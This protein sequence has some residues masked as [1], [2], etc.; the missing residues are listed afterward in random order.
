MILFS[1]AMSGGFNFQA[2]DGVNF[3]PR[4]I[5]SITAKALI[6]S[7][8]KNQPLKVFPGKRILWKVYKSGFSIYFKYKKNRTVLFV[9]IFTV[10]A[11]LVLSNWVKISDLWSL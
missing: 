1:G 10:L 7:L 3:T 5:F 11:P 4:Q 2:N 8:E 9:K 6:L